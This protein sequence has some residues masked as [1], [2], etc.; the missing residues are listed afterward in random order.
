MP[1][2]RRRVVAGCVALTALVGAPAIASAQYTAPPPAPGFHYIFDG[3]ATGSPASFDK[4]Q[5]ASGTAAQSATQGRA[6]LERGR[7]L[8]PGRRLAVRRPTGTRPQPFG[9]AVFR[10][11]YTVENTRCRDAQRRHHGPRA[12]LRLHRA[13]TNAVLAQKPTGYNYDVCGAARSR[14]ASAPRRRRRR[15]TRGRARRARSRP[16]RTRRTRR[17]RTPAP[18][19]RARREQRRQRQRRQRAPTGNANADNQQHWSQVY[20][21]HEVQVNESLTGGGP[22]PS[23]DPIKTGSVYGFRNLNASSRGRTSGSRR[24]SGTSSRSARSASSTRS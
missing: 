1:G 6:T 23:S 2:K 17:S 14:S 24:A 18:T 12:V 22:N 16:R 15:P 10:I 8:D 11:Q 5:F 4:W 13:D 20:C 7:R 9:D 3:T 21:G 19:A